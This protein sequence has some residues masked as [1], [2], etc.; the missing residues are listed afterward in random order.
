MFKSYAWTCKKYFIHEICFGMNKVPL[1]KHL[2]TQT[3]N[4][5]DMLKGNRKWVYLIIRICDIK[6]NQFLLGSTMR[7]IGAFSSMAKGGYLNNLIVTNK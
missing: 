7:L 5:D 4:T 6:Y 3:C 1:D 2:A